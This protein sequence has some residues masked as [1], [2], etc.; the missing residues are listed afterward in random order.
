M[1]SIFAIVKTLINVVVGVFLVWLAIG[2]LL[3]VAYLIL[4]LLFWPSSPLHK[5][6]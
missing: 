2:V 6:Y 5:N 1:G 3:N 4:W